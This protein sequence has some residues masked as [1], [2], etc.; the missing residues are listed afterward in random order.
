M[1]HAALLPKRGARAA[2]AAAAGRGALL[3]AAAR[4]GGRGARVRGCGAAG[5]WRS[6]ARAGVPFCVNDRLDV[7]LAV[8]ADVVHLG[9]DDLPLADALRRARG[10]RP[11]DLVV[12]FSTHNAGAGR[13]G[14][15]RP[16]PTT[17]ASAL[18]S[19]P[20]SKL[21][22]DPVGRARASWPRSAAPSPV[23][24]VA[25]GGITPEHAASAR[26][27]RRQRRRGHLGRQ[28]RP[29]PHRRRPPGSRR[30]PVDSAELVR[31]W[32]PELAGAGRLGE[33]GDRLELARG[34]RR[35]AADF[36]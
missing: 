11:A 33:L 5:C 4:E 31:R 30:P 21:N 16:A 20:R 29:R 34:R 6:A 18:S 36:G 35:R 9:Q 15:E 26:R 2:R 17:S 8:G 3:P 12:G 14:G 22:P 10:R 27:G 7:A 19:R 24:V 25:I 28:Q 32:R 1:T 23:P 13:R